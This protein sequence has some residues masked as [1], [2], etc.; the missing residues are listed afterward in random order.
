MIMICNFISPF[1][2]YKYKMIV[3]RNYHGD[4]EA[5]CSDTSTYTSVNLSQLSIV[6]ILY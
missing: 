3:M 2:I 5:T 1:N 6:I 4:C